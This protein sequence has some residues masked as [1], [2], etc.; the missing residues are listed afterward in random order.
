V[1]YGPRKGIRPFNRT[2]PKIDST[3]PRSTCFAQLDRPLG[4]PASDQL[5]NPLPESSPEF[6]DT[7]QILVSRTP[8]CTYRCNN[9]SVWSSAPPASRA[10][11]SFSMYTGILEYHQ[12][13]LVTTLGKDPGIA[14]QLLITGFC[15]D[16]NRENH[17]SEKH[18]VRLCTESAK[19]V[20]QTDPVPEKPHF[21]RRRG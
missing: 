3:F 15:Q 7:S 18:S 19:P 17:P 1:K 13:P 5:R 4:R 10:R 11:V 12:C 20:Y 2:V 9:R 8:V 16:G 21:H 14:H 6:G